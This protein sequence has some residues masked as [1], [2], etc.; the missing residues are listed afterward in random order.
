MG[1]LYHGKLL[2]ITRWYQQCKY[3]HKSLNN[4]ETNYGGHIILTSGNIQTCGFCYVV[5]LVPSLFVVFVAPMARHGQS[6]GVWCS[7]AS[8]QSK[9]LDPV[10]GDAKNVQKT[11][12]YMWYLWD[13]YWYIYIFFRYIF[14]DFEWL[15]MKHFDPQLYHLHHYSMICCTKP[16]IGDIYIY[17]HIYICI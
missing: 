17:I 4:M 15:W 5:Y 2:V 3:I 11:G 10:L 1:H 8:G 14:R 6:R 13:Y 9:W 7:T 12:S 16:V